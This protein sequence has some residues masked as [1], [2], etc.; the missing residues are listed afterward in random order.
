MKVLIIIASNDAETVWNAFR[1]ANTCL[2][3]DDTVTVFL[4]GKGVESVSINSIKFNVR[5]Q[6]EIFE[7]E[8]G[9]RIGCGVCVDSRSDT[10]PLLKDDLGCEMGSMQTLYALTHEADKILNF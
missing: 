2:T 8:G 5:E 10:M 3:H 9:K 6:V 4:L 1:Y 7:E